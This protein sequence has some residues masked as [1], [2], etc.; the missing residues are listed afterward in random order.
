MSEVKVKGLSE[1]QKYLDQL[2]MKI[3][4]NILRGALREGAKVVL[5]EAKANVPVSSGVLRDGLKISTRYRK[6]KVSASIKAKGKHGYLAQWME[7]GVKPHHIKG[8]DGKPLMIGA[9]FVEGVD[10]PGI[11]PRPFLRPALDSQAGAALVAVGEAIKKRLTKAGI[12][13]AAEVDI[14]AEA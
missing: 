10:H 3:E 9:G 4:T 6:G 13:G 12:E 7:F 8:K 11:S 14:E 5:A 1:L 2:P